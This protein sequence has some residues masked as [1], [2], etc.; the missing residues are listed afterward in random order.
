MRFLYTTF[1]ERDTPEK[2]TR[3]IFFYHLSNKL[4]HTNNGINFFLYC[5]SCQKFRSDLRDLLYCSNV[6][7][8]TSSYEGAISQ[9]GVTEISCIWY[10]LNPSGFFIYSKSF[11]RFIWFG[12]YFTKHKGNLIS[13]GDCNCFTN[14]SVD[15]DEF[16]CRLWQTHLKVGKLPIVLLVVICTITN[17][18]TFIQVLIRNAWVDGFTWRAKFCFLSTI[19]V[20]SIIWQY[21]NISH[22][23]KPLGLF[24]LTA[25][26]HRIL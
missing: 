10:W 5:I 9:S 21:T 15:C 2:Y 11:V 4:Y 16:L 19:F 24:S 18:S 22:L 6:S 8:T 7:S 23:N 13:P 12:K 3:L 17:S 25:T 26:P 1:V 14:S 20:I